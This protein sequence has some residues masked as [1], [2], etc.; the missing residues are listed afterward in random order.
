MRNISCAIALVTLGGC[1]HGSDITPPRPLA[2]AAADR[3]TSVQYEVEK[4]A[5]LGG[6]PSRG[7][8]IN[9]SGSVAGYSNLPGNATRHATYWH[10]GSITDLGTLGGPNSTVAWPG[11]NDRGVIAGISETADMDVLN[12]DWSC[13][14]FFPSVT[15]HVCRGFVWE[16]GHMRGLPVFEG[17]INGMATG[18]NNRGQVVGWAENKIHDPTCNSPQV[19]QF[20]AALWEPGRGTM[21]Q[22]K[23]LAGDSTSAATAINDRGQV[24]G[25][26]G[27]CDVAVGEFS[28]RHAVIWED[29]R[30]RDIGNLGGVAWNTPMDINESGDIVGFADLPGDANGAYNAHAFLW[31]PNGGIRDLGTLPGDQTSEALAINER[32]QIVGYSCGETAC[33]AFLWQN[34]VMAQLDSLVKPKFADALPSAQ[35]INA[36]GLITGRVTEHVSHRGLAFIARPSGRQ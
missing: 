27:A 3:M 8:A 23:P 30:V 25:I 15:H 16:N 31:T 26:S 7:N 34:G 35:D 1:G 12:E 22:L 21:R 36:A 20:R 18:V 6:T 9:A 19:L 24:V 14:A 32:R 4:L 17:G 10:G 13:S 33:R 5:S 29:G 11:I 28:A 2:S